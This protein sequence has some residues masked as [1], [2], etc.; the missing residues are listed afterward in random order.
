[1]SSP[2]QPAPSARPRSRLVVRLLAAAVAGGLLCLAFPT[3]DVWVAAP[4]SLALL[5]WALTAAGF[6]RGLLLGLVAGLAFFVPT[7]QWSGIY[8]GALPWLA[9]STLEA[10]FLALA[11]GLYGWLSRRGGVHPFA[12]AVVWVVTE[13]FRGRAPYG[14]FPWLKLAFGQ[15]D[16]PFGR[17]VALGGPP[18]VAF[19]IALTGALLALAA[20]RVWPALRRGGR[21]LDR[22]SGRR[23]SR[24]VG[25]RMAPVAAAVVLSV[26]GLAV[27]LPTDG[28]SA[29]FVGVQGNVA[30]PGLEFNAER[31]AVLDNHVAATMGEV[32]RIKDGSVP[33]PD[34]VVWPENASDIDPLRNA[35]AKALILQTVAALGRPLIVG[36][37]LEEPPGELSNVSLLFEPGRGN[38]ERYVKRHPV[39]FAEYIPNRAFWRQF[40][41]E[42]D[43]VRSDFVAGRD[44]G[45]FDVTGTKGQSVRAGLA[46]CFEVAYDDIMRDTVD[47]GANVLVVQ[48]NNATFGY[49]AESPQQLAISRVRAM[50]FGRSVVHVSTVGQSA[51]ITPDGTA[52]QVTS[53]FTQAVISGAL[54]LRDQLTVATRVGAAP[55]WAA[56]AALV[57][58]LG[59]S[60]AR[61]PRLTKDRDDDSET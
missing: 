7:L 5:A 51:L 41:A 23:P 39:P 56:L 20:V 18:L 60:V 54:P 24:A 21:P 45:L 53:L 50:E 1:M 35:D 9:L 25:S 15:A 29:Q 55:E 32:A 8:V 10:L 44:V 58:L 43:L 27:P 36:G 46:I 52:H 57:V 4:V 16:S 14:G 12:F 19:V 30:R 38:T 40:S 33:V 3:F 61:R 59:A 26:A 37:L 34:L 22:P 31:R 6:R 49:T 11:G 42:V 2:P 17:L 28:Q 13:G 48:T 47:A